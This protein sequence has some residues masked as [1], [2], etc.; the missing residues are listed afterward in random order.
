MWQ[1]DPRK[2]ARQERE[3]EPVEINAPKPVMK[4]NT[5][6]VKLGNGWKWHI[7]CELCNGEVVADDLFVGGHIP[8]T[9]VSKRGNI[10]QAVSFCRCKIG[11]YLAERHRARGRQVVYY[12]EVDR[13]LHD[14]FIKT[15]AE[16]LEF[17]RKREKELRQSL[18]QQKPDDDEFPF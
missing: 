4:D 6:E 18:K 1:R 9:Y 5:I 3:P 17:N 11:T 16:I 10:V 15:W 2:A 14:P 12:D 8:I 13:N 7:H